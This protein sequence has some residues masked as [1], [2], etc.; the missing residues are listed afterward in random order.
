MVMQPHQL[1]VV[2]EHKELQNKFGDLVTFIETSPIYKNLDVEEKR[3]LL[4]QCRY[5]SGYAWI[6]EQRIKNFK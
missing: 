3:L 6:L 5:M 1:R 4:E 2:E